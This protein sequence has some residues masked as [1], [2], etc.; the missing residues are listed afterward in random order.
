MIGIWL[1][2]WTVSRQHLTSLKE[3]VETVRK[4]ALGYFPT[5]AVL[6]EALGVQLDVG[7]CFND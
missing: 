2:E 1:A 5:P 7:G 4:M 6:W 3:E